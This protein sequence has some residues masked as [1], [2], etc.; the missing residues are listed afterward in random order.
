MCPPWPRAHTQ[1]RPYRIKAFLTSMSAA[2]Y[3]STFGPGLRSGGE[4]PVT[5]SWTADP[6]RQ[7]LD[8]RHINREALEEDVVVVGVGDFEQ[9][10]V[11]GGGGVV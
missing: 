10:L 5:A 2:W 6:C 8:G 9:G 4:G 3:N 1:V 7:G 11:R